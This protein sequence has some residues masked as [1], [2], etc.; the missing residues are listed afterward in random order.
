[1]S[2]CIFCKIIAGEIPTELI[3][4][5][6]NVVA[7]NDI[8]PSS[9]IHIL[10]VPRKHIKDLESVDTEDGKIMVEMARAVKILAKSKKLSRYRIIINGGGY[11]EV[12][13]LH[14]HLQGGK[15]TKRALEALINDNK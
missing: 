5:S 6:Q 3:Y 11:L 2:D 1:M 4:E 8:N 15:F 12:H 13:H 10:I 9:K 14:W 7:F